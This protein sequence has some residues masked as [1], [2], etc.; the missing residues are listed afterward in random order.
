[1]K[2]ILLILFMVLVF[3][4]C[5]VIY[6]EYAVPGHKVYIQPEVQL[7]W[8]YYQPCWS[9]Y[10]WNPWYWYGAY[11]WQLPYMS[12]TGYGYY[13]VE[14]PYV[15]RSGIKR[16]VSKREL[17]GPS[18][19]IQRS[20]RRPVSSTGGS[21]TQVV[22]TTTKRTVRATTGARTGGSRTSGKRI[23]RK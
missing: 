7:H 18:K 12:T 9:S 16:T 21:R 1:M 4:G 6:H 19:A 2:K 10:W 8:S 11:Y 20:R 5:T 22:R 14:V 13:S 23:K 15:P 3:A 17:A